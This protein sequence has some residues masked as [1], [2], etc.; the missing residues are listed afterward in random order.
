[1]TDNESA[2]IMQTLAKQQ[3]CI[4]ELQARC[5]ALTGACVALAMKQGI[6]GTRLLSEIQRLTRLEFQGQLES[7]ERSD[8]Q[9]AAHADIR[10]PEDVLPLP[11]L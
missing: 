3:G 1:M 10:N 9:L 11:E 5:R 4:L 8:P 7:L 6:D 2:A